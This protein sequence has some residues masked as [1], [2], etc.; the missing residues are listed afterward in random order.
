MNN[1][2]NQI[3]VST[4]VKVPVEKAWHFWTTPEHITRW[5]AASP[6]WHTPTASL[7]LRAG[8]VFSYRME[9]RDG[10]M[11]FDFNGTVDE[12]KPHEL[13]R[14][15]MGDGRKWNVYFRPVDGGTELTEQFDP[16]GTNPRELQ[17]QGWQS[18]LD[19]FRRHAEA[20]AG[21]QQLQFDIYIEK[22][23]ATVYAAMIAPGTYQ[24][25]TSEFNETSR[26]EGDWAEGSPIRFV[27]CDKEGKTHGMVSRIRKNIPGEYISIEHL[28]MITDGREVMEGPGVDAWY[29]ALENY[30]FSPEGNGTRVHVSLDANNDYASYFNTTWPKALAKLKSICEA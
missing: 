20:R 9:A 19:N 26:Y 23:A 30:T 6:D 24:E 8:G 3:T 1:S 4:T 22:P 11:G 2:S 27:G 15:T 18:I 29:G 12:V 28:G 16:E 21:E 14:N 10:S 25:W 7:D 13:I 5:N 17:Q